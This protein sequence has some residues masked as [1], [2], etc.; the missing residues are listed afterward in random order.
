M[1]PERFALVVGINRYDTTSTLGLNDLGNAEND[2]E[3]I[4]SELNE[5][6]FVTFVLTTGRK[7]KATPNEPPYVTKNEILNKLSSLINYA[8]KSR[9]RTGRP[10]IILFYFAGHGLNIVGR[11]YVLPSNFKPSFAE[12]VPVMG[13]SIDEIAN[14][15]SW[16]EPALKVII[17]D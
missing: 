14:R 4:A 8:A 6:A 9:E 11:D 7:I 5:A 3:G 1:L 16:A 17:S 13:I 10:P 12:D 2:A 15:I